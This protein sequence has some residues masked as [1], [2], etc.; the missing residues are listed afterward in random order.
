MS[1]QYRLVERPNLRNLTLPRKQNPTIQ[2]GFV[3]HLVDKALVHNHPGI[4][5]PLVKIPIA[6]LKLQHHF[7][8]FVVE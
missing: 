2:Q 1:V 4:F 3:F 7:V 5:I 6:V 8:H